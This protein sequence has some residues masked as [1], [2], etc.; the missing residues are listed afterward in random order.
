MNVMHE[1]DHYDQKDDV[2]NTNEKQELKEIGNVN[3]KFNEEI[4]NVNVEDNNENDHS[5]LVR[6]VTG[7]FHQ[8]E[9]NM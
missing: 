7:T 3:V 6:V 9:K 8:S 1:S 4:G 5:E 2:E